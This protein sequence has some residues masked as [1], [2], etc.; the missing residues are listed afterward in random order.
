MWTLSLKT[1]IMQLSCVTWNDKRCLATA[2]TDRKEFKPADK[3]EALRISRLPLKKIE[4]I[5]DINDGNKYEWYEFRTVREETYD[6]Y[7]HKKG[8]IVNND[9][10]YGRCMYCPRTDTLRNNTMGEFYGG[11]A[12]D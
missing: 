11:S 9:S 1:T 4:D 8:D 5:P 2:F 7:W 6:N 10:K 12:V 3:Q